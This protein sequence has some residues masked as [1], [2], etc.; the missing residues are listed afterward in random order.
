[1]LS[2]HLLIEREMHGVLDAAGTLPG[3]SDP[4]LSSVCPASPLLTK[5]RTR[6]LQRMITLGH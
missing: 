2:A 6:D 3:A 1:M 5:V 4:F